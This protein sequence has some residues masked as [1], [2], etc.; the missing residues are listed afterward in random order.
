MSETFFQVVTEAIREF[1]QYGFDSVERLQYWIERI[2]KAAQTSL[3]PLPTL[4]RT[5]R[6]VLSG[7]YKRLIEEGKIIR[8]HPEISRFTIDRVK[9]KLRR[10]LDRRVMASSN[11]IRLNREQMI[12]KT[13]QRFSGWASSVPIGGSKAVD[14]KDTKDHIRQAL[15]SMPF[16]ERRLHIDQG[17]KFTAALNEILAVEGGAIAVQWN[18]QWRRPGYDYR[19]DHKERDGKIYLMRQSQAR[20]KG[21]VKPGAAGYYDDITKVGEEVFCSCFGTYI[22]VLGRLPEDMLTAKGKTAL[23]DARKKIAALKRN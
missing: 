11:L 2:R 6:G 13:V 17:H 3:T 21:L 16:T 23:A 8:T 12:E 14:V 10:E 15:T 5:L 18:S 9:P 22:Y 1:E 7:I 4:E 19:E 20:E